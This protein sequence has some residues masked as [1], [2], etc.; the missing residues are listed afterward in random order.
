MLITMQELLKMEKIRLRCFKQFI[1]IK[2]LK[3]IALLNSL[4]E[5]LIKSNIYFI[6]FEFYN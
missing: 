3:M 6:L 1:V 2:I 5:K 4:I